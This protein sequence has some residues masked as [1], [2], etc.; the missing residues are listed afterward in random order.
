MEDT[1]RRRANSIN[2]AHEKSLDIGESGEAE[3]KMRQEVREAKRERGA[4]GKE[5]EANQGNMTEEQKD[6]A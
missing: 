2:Q 3:V 6:R 1:A 5:Q 4:R